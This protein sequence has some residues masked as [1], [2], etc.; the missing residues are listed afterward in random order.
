MEKAYKFRIYPNENQEILIQKTFGSCRFIYNHYLAKRIEMYKTDKTTISYNQCSKDMTNLK[1]ELEWLKEIDSIALQSSLKDL[2]QAYQNFFRRVKQGDSKSG[3]PHFKSKKDNKKSYK[4]KFTNNNIQVLDKQIKLPKLGLVKCKVSKQIQ[5]R[6]LN[7]TISQNPSGKYFV[8]V[9]CTEVNI[10]QYSPTGTVVG[11][12]LGIKEFA[13]TSDGVHIENPKF[14]KKSEKKLAKSQRK[15]S[16]KTIGSS[17]RNKARIKVARCHEKIVNQ[18][19]DFLHKL[20]TQ[21]V[22]DYD[23]ICLETLKVK[24]MIKN[25][26]LAKAISDVSW[27]EFV[28][29]IGYKADWYGK[30]KQQIDT[31]YASSQLCSVCGY[32]N[33]ET[34]DLSVREWECSECHTIHDR[35]ENASNNILKEGLRLLST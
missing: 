16:R 30:I 1:K 11:I 29:Q 6:I 31:Y 8:S 28:R 35:D 26:K 7:A 18:R 34:K 22:K 4:T 2:D 17:N 24:N 5:G 27:S 10:P 3:F 20:S 23:I 9:C 25:H 21:I 15:L 13:V 19:K 32:K 14:L 33:T 12:D